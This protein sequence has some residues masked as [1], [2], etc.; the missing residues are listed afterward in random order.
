MTPYAGGGAG[1]YLY[2]ED[3]D[4]AESGENVRKNLVSYHALG[5]VEFRQSPRLGFAAEVQYTHVPNEFNGLADVFD[6]HN[7]GGLQVRGKVLFGR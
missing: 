3:F 6:E 1:L 4:F 7:L 2:R 5:G